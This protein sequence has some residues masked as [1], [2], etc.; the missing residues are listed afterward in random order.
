MT[1]MK[2]IYC[3]ACGL[4]I[5]G[6]ISTL[7]AQTKTAPATLD[8][9]LV[10]L[11]GMRREMAQSS[12]GLVRAQLLVARIQVQEQRVNAV[13][14]Q[15]A[16]IQNDVAA[17]RDSMVPLTV[18]LSQAEALAARVTAPD[19]E[20]R[21]VELM[22]ADTKA[23]VL[24]RIAEAEE[25]IQGLTARYNELANQFATEQGRWMDFNGRLDA[26]ERSLEKR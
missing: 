14:R 7:A 20:R 3:C 10:E 21:Q 22:L 26:L 16:E 18:E 23:R 12:A 1:N 24:P 4:A 15:I 5:L 2:G 9:L 11:R 17:V 6:F 8:D 25:R 19:E 13:N